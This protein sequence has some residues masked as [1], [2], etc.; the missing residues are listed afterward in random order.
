LRKK[1]ELPLIFITVIA[2]SVLSLI[3]L[4]IVKYNSSDGH[5]VFFV[6]FQSA[7]LILGA[8]FERSVYTVF[9]RIHSIRLIR[10]WPGIY[11]FVVVLSLLCL[12]CVI[13]LDDQIDVNHLFLMTPIYLAGLVLT[14]ERIAF[15]RARNKKLLSQFLFVGTRPAVFF[16]L[17]MAVLF[18]DGGFLLSFVALYAGANLVAQVAVLVIFGNKKKENSH[19]WDESM[20]H[21][22][23][24]VKIATASLASILPVQ[25]MVLD[26]APSLK[27]S[28]LLFIR[29]VERS[30]LPFKSLL[31]VVNNARSR[32]FARGEILDDIV[33]AKFRK[34]I[35]GIGLLMS[36]AAISIAVFISLY[37]LDAFRLIDLLALMLFYGALFFTIYIGPAATFLNMRAL[38][39]FVTISTV[40]ACGVTICIYLMLPQS[41]S[42]M[43]FLMAFH[44]LVIHGLVYRK[45]I[46]VAG[47]RFYW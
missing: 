20:K 26:C 7:L 11:R 21:G 43:L 5:F 27:S 38:N 31:T 47:S 1:L 2:S 8:V 17:L 33:S 46:E 23:E 14:A 13:Y 36:F 41:L 3:S 25:Y 29:I 4:V 15:L 24:F 45:V 28:E 34:T 9:V 18:A 16:L 22:F 19:F 40:I 35:I 10:F 44:S 42:V 12:F 6:Q 32:A 39:K 30:V 37:L